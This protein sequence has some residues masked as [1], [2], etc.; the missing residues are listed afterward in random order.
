MNTVCLQRVCSQRLC[1]PLEQ[2]NCVWK[3]E[4]EPSADTVNEDV[5]REAEVFIKP[6]P[7][8]NRAVLEGFVKESVSDQPHP[9]NELFSKDL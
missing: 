7:A 5:F 4:S 1:N 3:P 6:A 9:P 8:F 2:Q